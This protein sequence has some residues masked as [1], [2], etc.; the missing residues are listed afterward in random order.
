M[1]QFVLYSYVLSLIYITPWWSMT[2]YILRRV[3]TITKHRGW[4]WVAIAR[5]GDFFVAAN[6]ITTKTI[7]RIICHFII[8]SLLNH[9]TSKILLKE[10]YFTKI[11]FLYIFKF[12]HLNFLQKSFSFEF[13]ELRNAQNVKFMHQNLKKMFLLISIY[14]EKWYI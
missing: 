10:V 7:F 8:W 14:G 3:H 13:Q 12:I 5:G 9:I 6:K 2:Y 11:L 4:I 1:G